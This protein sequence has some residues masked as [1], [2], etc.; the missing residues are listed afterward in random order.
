MKARW[1]AALHSPDFFQRL[2]HFLFGFVFFRLPKSVRA[3]LFRGT[4][5]QCPICQTQLRRFMPLYR[6]NM[7]W[8]PVCKSLQR[9]RLVWLFLQS[10][11]IDIERL[12]R[13]LLHFAPEP[14][15]AAALSAL[16]NI[17]YISA[18]LFDAAAMLKL[19]LCAIDL[20]D[21]SFDFV[22][23]SHVLE[24]V[25]DDQRAM[26][27]IQRVLKPGGS[28]LILVPIIADQTFEDP[29]VTNPAE[30]E[31]LFGQEDHVRRYGPDVTDRLRNAGFQVQP[32]RGSDIVSAAQAQRA[33]I[34]LWEPLFL[35]RKA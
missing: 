10:D 18:D 20:P 31:R 35:C 3:G 6:Q 12:P 7:H 5:Y 27:E 33:D 28:A 25:P 30:R 1:V 24:H 21:A 16:P 13:N 34:D 23:C 2:T 29:S 26:R 14:A 9:H 8:C 19:D 4:A 11:A 15:L 32:L 22:Y 17:H